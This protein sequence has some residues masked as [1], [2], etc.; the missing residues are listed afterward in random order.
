MKEIKLLLDCLNA[1]DYSKFD[2][3]SIN[4]LLD[5]RECE[6][7]DSEWCRVDR[8]ISELK[9]QYNYTSENQNQQNQIRKEAFFI[10]ERN[11]GTELSDYVSDDFG[12]I[13]DSM[14]VG[15]KDEW[16]SKLIEAY[17]NGIIP[18]GEL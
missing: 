6:P 14:L 5:S 11:I 9:N 2:E 4:N 8:E 12:L 3:D 10:I 17:R 16:L 13:F 1:I 18:A 7:F 15:Y